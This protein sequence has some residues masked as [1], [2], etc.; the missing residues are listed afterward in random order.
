MP[1]ARA[2]A[3]SPQKMAADANPTFEVATIK[4]SLPDE[5][6]PQ[7]NL[8][9]RPFKT[10]GTSAKELIKIGYNMRGRQVLGGPAWIEDS[11]FDVVAEPDM[12][13]IPNEEQTRA[14]VRKLLADRFH[15]AIHINQQIFPVMAVTID[16]NS[17]A[18]VASDP[19]SDVR[20]NMDGRQAP[21]GQLLV[22]FTGTT[23][24]QFL[25]LIMNFFQDRQLVDET[26]LTGIYDITL[27]VPMST[28]QN[29]TGA[30]PEDDRGNALI[31][32]A[33]QLGFKFTAKKEPLPIIVVDHLEMPTAN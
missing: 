22:Q 13:G 33:Q 12:E 23:I 26:G 17:R 8:R 30:G 2:Q 5:I 11:K 4:P 28:F 20:G 16:K 7:F 25:S 32:A 9:G 15:L 21:D 3:G 29:A 24:A 1:G 6:H 31:Q 27:K 10:R 18:L 19:K 14:M